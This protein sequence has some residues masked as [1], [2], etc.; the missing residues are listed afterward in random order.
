MSILK[1][2]ENK[3][4][5][6]FNGEIETDYKFMKIN[7]VEIKNN[8]L[9]FNCSI[10]RLHPDY[11]KFLCDITTKTMKEYNIPKFLKPIYFIKALFVGMFSS[12]F[13]K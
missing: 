4:M 11:F 5:A 3:T 9:S 8:T 13:S 1:V 6:K 7:K 10:N 12:K 2:K